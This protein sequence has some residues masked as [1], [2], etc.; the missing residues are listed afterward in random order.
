MFR[1]MYILNCSWVCVEVEL[2]P[3]LGVFPV[4]LDVQAVVCFLVCFR[5]VSMLNLVRISGVL[6]VCVNTHSGVC[7]GV[8]VLC[9]SFVCVHV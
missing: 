9:V 8:H 6:S 7:V 1:L 4:C 3:S 2:G 5:C